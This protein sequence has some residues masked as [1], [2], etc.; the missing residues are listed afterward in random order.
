[1]RRASVTRRVAE[2]VPINDFCEAV[3]V[4]A[5]HRRLIQEDSSKKI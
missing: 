3:S 1:M 5:L 2:G 4:C